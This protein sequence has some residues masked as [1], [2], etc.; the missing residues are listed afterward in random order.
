VKR[1]V[2]R[3]LIPAAAV[4]FVLIAVAGSFD[5]GLEQPV[6]F[7]HY[8][9]ATTKQLSCFFCHPYA[10]KSAN[11]GLPPVEK[12]MLCHKVIASN[13]EPIAKLRG[14]YDRKEPIQW[15]RVTAL[16]DFVHFNHQSHIAR[17]HD[18]S[19]CHGDVKDMDRVTLAHRIDMNFC[20]TCHRQNKASVDCFVCHY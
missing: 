20:I 10:A 8:V 7:S 5:R 6:P 1:L 18:C 17:G 14:Y 13:F 16:P 2:V 4:I 12:C 15:A 9:H 19:E 3:L 11:A